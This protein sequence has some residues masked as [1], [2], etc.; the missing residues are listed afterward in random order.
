MNPINTN[1]GSATIL[2]MLI[3]G[4]IMT[5][6]LGFNWLV[7]EH[8]KASEGLKKKA[9]AILKARSAYDSLIYLMLNGQTSQKDMVLSGVQDLTKLTAIPLNGKEVSLEDDLYIKVQE[10]N[11]LLS[12]ANINRSAIERLIKNISP[13]ENP[14][15][16]LDSLLDWIS[17]GDFARINGAKKSYYQ[18]QQAPYQPRNYALQYKEE[19]M[20]VRGIGR[21]LYLKIEPY[22]TVLP[23]SG[24]NPNTASDEVL[25]AYLD[26]NKESLNLMKDYMSKAPISSEA[27]LF[28]LTGRRLATSGEEMHLYPSRFMEVTVSVGSPRSLYIIKAG[29]N[30]ANNVS[31]PYSVVYW[32]EE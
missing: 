21:D 16:A 10:S 18:G 11:G 27:A 17:P 26:I 19:L 32:R 7:R 25:Q 31:A 12:L 3:A 2:I 9:E 15:I 14:S 23:S 8:I 4:V 13:E 30:F 20:F 1:K 5:V 29:L 22:L 28:F 24:F 6:G